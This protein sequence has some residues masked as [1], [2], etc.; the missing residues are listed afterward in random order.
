MNC[1][2]SY[3]CKLWIH[4]LRNNFSGGT[5]F[6]SSCSSIDCLSAI[7]QLFGGGTRSC[8]RACGCTMNYIT[9]T[10]NGNKSLHLI[11]LDS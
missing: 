9:C 2:L 4:A 5:L 10:I 8:V 7:A 1:R 6:V 11:E 3:K